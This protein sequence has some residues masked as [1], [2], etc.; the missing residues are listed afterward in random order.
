MVYALALQ[1]RG[2]GD[3]SPRQTTPSKKSESV[4]P[5]DPTEIK[6]EELSL[7]NPVKYSSSTS[8]DTTPPPLS[9]TALACKKNSLYYHNEPITAV[10]VD[11]FG[12]H[13]R[14]DFVDG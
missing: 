13:S 7:A 2:S 5:K 3:R 10:Q 9:I 6:L 11:Q 1:A 14:F 4:D 12:G 8:F